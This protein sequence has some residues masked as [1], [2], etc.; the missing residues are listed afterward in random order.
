[1]KTDEDHEMRMA[2]PVAVLH[3]GWCGKDR[4]LRVGEHSNNCVVGGR[5]P[6]CGGVATVWRTTWGPR[7]TSGVIY[8]VD[9]EEVTEDRPEGRVV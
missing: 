5:C 3:C 6:R 7:G 1:M 9:E 2:L 4:D 8:I